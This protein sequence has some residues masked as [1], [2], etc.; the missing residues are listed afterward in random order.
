MLQGKARQGKQWI[1][2]EQEMSRYDPGFQDETKKATPKSGLSYLVAGAGFEPTTFG[3][4]ARRATRLLHPASTCNIISS[5]ESFFN[6]KTLLKLA[7]LSCTLIKFGNSAGI[8]Q[9]LLLF[10][11]T[12]PSK[13]RL[14]NNITIQKLGSGSWIWTND[15]RV[16]SPTSY[17]T[18]PSRNNIANNISQLKHY[19]NCL[20]KFAS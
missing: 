6:Q 9:Q 5:F 11:I 20:F 15:L 12:E 17:Q 13:L 7:W 2:G 10:K 1:G 14:L 4:W 16:M 8:N 18:A 19:S 3:L